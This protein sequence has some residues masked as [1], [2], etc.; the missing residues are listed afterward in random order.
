MKRRNF[1]LLSATGVAAIG[2]SYWYL[3]YYTS[4]FDSLITEPESLSYI[5]SRE[6]ISA[7]GRG[8]RKQFP[9]E[10]SEHS[11]VKLL[12]ADTQDDISAIAALKRG[13]KND[14]ETGNT[15]MIDGWIL[16]ITE[17]RQCAL[18]SIIQSN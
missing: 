3:N 9:S 16:S 10:D 17:A 13:I 7:I 18:F 15:V 4:E 2:T 6:T 8:Y 14:F 1:I 12:L 5:W 11:L